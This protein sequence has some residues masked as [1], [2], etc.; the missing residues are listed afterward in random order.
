MEKEWV[1]EE[2]VGEDEWVDEDEC[3]VG[4]GVSEGTGK[5]GSGGRGVG[6]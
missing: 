4:G 6:G 2:L 1:E 3:V 5:V